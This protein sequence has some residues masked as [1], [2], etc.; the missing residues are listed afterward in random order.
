[1]S[2]K[3]L[4]VDDAPVV[5]LLLKSIL[6]K[7]GF[8]VVAEAGNGNEALD[9]YKDSSPDVVTM[10]ITMPEANGIEGVKMILA[11]DPN[12]KIVMI[13][14]IDQ[15]KYLLEAIKAGAADYIV[16]PFEDNRVITAL[17]KATSKV[18]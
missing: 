10:D 9:R 14:A 17:Q 1:M 3:V 15:R 8:E 11:H 4:I 12:A 16:K 7:N 6:E 2:K 5:R 18:L 13:T